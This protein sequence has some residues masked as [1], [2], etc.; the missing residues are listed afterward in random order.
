M[1]HLTLNN[2]LITSSINNNYKFLFF[3]TILIIY[4]M[5]MDIALFVNLQRW[6]PPPIEVSSQKITT[7]NK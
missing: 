2:R 5:W 1:A 3:G 6:S 7:I 4:F